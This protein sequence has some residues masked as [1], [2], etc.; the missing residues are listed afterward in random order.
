MYIF[1]L[2]H[3]SYEEILFSI[4]FL[5]ANG[6]VGG[7]AKV[8]CE[9]SSELQGPFLLSDKKVDYAYFIN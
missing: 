8:D 6:L 7:K 9:R 1:L 5:H 3:Q 2:L 4:T